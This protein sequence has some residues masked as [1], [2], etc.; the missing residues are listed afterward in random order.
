M[1]SSQRDDTIDLMNSEYQWREFAYLLAG[2]LAD[3]I[4]YS[5]TPSEKSLQLLDQARDKFPDS[6]LV[7]NL[8]EMDIDQLNPVE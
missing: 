4:H 8:I 3:E 2:A 1:N 5:Q 6:E 7:K